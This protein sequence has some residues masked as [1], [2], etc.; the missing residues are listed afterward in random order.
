MSSPDFKT[1]LTELNQKGYSRFIV[2]LSECV[3]MDSTFLG[4]LAGF[5][6]KANPNCATGKCEVELANPNARIS[7]LLEN[8]GVLPLFKVTTG[9]RAIAGRCQSLRARPGQSHAG[10]DYAHLPG[11]AQ[12]THGRQPGERRAVQRRDTVSGRG[13]EESRKK[14]VNSLARGKHFNFTPAQARRNRGRA[15]SAARAWEAFRA[16]A[17]RPARPSAAQPVPAPAAAA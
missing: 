16:A 1:L 5:G 14:F 10:A 11:G 12:D 17:F 4:V 3:L 2:D 8:L 15:I 13:F 9:A 6:L 7:E